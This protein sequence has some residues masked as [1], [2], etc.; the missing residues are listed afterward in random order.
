MPGPTA[1]CF[2]RTGMHP[3][4]LAILIM[5]AHP[6]AVPAR[7]AETAPPPQRKTSAHPPPTRTPSAT[8]PASR[9][10]TIVVRGRAA[11]P[12]IRR[13]ALPQTTAGINRRQID[14]TLNIID[15]EDALRYMPSLMLRKRYNGDTQA[16]L[17]TRTWG[18]ASSAR[19]LVYVDDALISALISNNTTTGAPRWG[20]V[21]P[22]QIERIDMLY[23]PF[24]AEYPGNSMGGVVLI[25]TR[26]PDHFTATIK[27]TGSVQTYGDYRTHGN[28]G[29]SNSAV[30]LGNRIG[31]LSWLF[32][33]NREE[34]L[35][36]PLYYVLDSTFPT[37]TTG[38]I[39]ALSKTGTAANVMGAGALLHSTMNNVTLRMAYD[40]TRWLRLNY[41]IG[42]WDNQTR[43]RSQTYLTTASGTPTFGGVAGFANDT[44]SFNE[45]HLMNAV[46]LKTNTQG[47]WDGEAVF[48]DYDY[49]KDIQRNPAGV[50]GGT[51]FT[52]NGY[53][54]RMDGS[55]WRTGDLKAIWRPDGPTGAHEL[56]FGGHL[57]RYHLENPTYNTGNWAAPSDAGNGT[58]HSA[59]R[60]TT[61][62]YA[63]W[64]QEVWKFLPGWT[65]TLG[66]RV[67]FWGASNGF[68]SAGSVATSQPNAHSTN[69]SP[70]ATLAWRINPGWT[71]KLS[72]GEA[73][74]YP[75][76]SELY[77]IVSTGGTYAVPNANLKPERVFSGE[78]MIERHLTNGS[79]R[80]SLFQE[81]TRDALISQSTLLNSI[82]TTTFQNVNAVRN[83]GVEFVAERHDLLV[84]GLDLSNSVTYV[85]SRILSDPG[86]RS[87]AGTSANGKHVPY[88]PKWR[89][90]LQA[91]WH[92]TQRLDLSAALRYQGKMYSTLDNT[93]SV[94]HVFGAFDTFLV[95]DVHVHWHVAGPL[96]LDAG[97]DNINNA[98]YFEYHPFPMRTYVGDLKAAF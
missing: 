37:A 28:Y 13:F 82:Y 73:W 75:T 26:M 45:D 3:G 17:Q 72:F 87:S 16:T 59:G 2:R 93:D 18:I 64:A 4:V 5:C 65:L 71:T 35:S 89:D 43:A 47:H 90:T 41:T 57:D 31:R 20:M 81:N 39:R 32:S 56:S 74:R 62:T 36:E 61:T 98:R 24:A 30:T 86:F 80:L 58:L 85:D 55:G 97:I 12:E 1:P 42:F 51:T 46:S 8:V 14:V 6:V 68:N 9:T 44:Y 76:V 91:T 33:A 79:L 21:A 52:R 83:R 25:T 53:I 49:L 70:K 78:A 7:A 96:T 15:T 66:G 10:E 48:T 67:E 40:V 77:Q 50:L 11:A 29:T 69:G 92:A 84:R 19:S 95:V 63:L 88:V 27:Q 94:S 60:G 23:G 34:T 38:G 22:E 54:A